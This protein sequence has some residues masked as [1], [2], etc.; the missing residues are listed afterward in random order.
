M[1]FESV[2]L[3]ER[4]NLLQPGFS[5]ELYRALYGA[6]IH[7]RRAIELDPDLEPTYCDLGTYYKVKGLKKRKRFSDKRLRLTLF[8]EVV[9]NLGMLCEIN[10]LE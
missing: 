4:I 10:R 6:E 1:A 8:G 2:K 7:F 3:E 5:I 9:S